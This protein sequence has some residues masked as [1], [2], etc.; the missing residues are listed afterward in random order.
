MNYKFFIKCHIEPYHFMVRREVS[1]TYCRTVNIF[2]K[3]LYPA[4]GTARGN[5]G[6]IERAEVAHITW[7]TTITFALPP[8]YSWQPPPHYA[9]QLQCSQTLPMQSMLGKKIDTH[10]NIER[11][12]VS[13]K[14]FQYQYATVQTCNTSYSQTHAW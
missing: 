6:K 4:A 12:Y 7:H 2:P 8:G 13:C 14:V 9:S 10:A 1:A 11:V 5:S 3:K